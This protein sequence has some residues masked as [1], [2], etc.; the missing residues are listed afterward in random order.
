MKKIISKREYDTE[1]ATFIKKHFEGTY[2]DP[3]GY[4]ICLFQNPKGLYFFYMN[5]GSESPYAKED[6]KCVSKVKAEEWIKNN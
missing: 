5:G 3:K 2:G 1:N 6:I 4:E